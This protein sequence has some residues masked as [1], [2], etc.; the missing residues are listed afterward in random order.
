MRQGANKTM[1]QRQQPN[2]LKILECFIS[3]L[4]CVNCENGDLL[5]YITS[6][7]YTRSKTRWTMQ[8]LCFISD[9]C[10]CSSN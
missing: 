2:L 9:G 3:A 4:I 7:N 5:P 10:V 1:C 6:F 8:S